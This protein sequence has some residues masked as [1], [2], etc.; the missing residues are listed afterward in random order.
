MSEQAIRRRAMGTTL[1]IRVMQQHSKT[2]TKEVLGATV[3]G[4]LTDLGVSRGAEEDILSRV[5]DI[6]CANGYDGEAIHH[7]EPQSGDER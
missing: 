4:L 1:A 2:D 3:G 7:T 6:L 5:R